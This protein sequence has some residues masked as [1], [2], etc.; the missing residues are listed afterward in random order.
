[1]LSFIMINENVKIDNTK[2]YHLY[3]VDINAIE[4]N[5]LDSLQKQITNIL[6]NKICIL[7]NKLYIKEILKY[8]DDLNDIKNAIGILCKESNVQMKEFLE[9]IF[10]NSCN[11]N[12]K[13][14]DSWK[15]KI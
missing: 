3:D 11:T 10:D 15:S 9:L 4:I 5:N 1:M 12:K 14:F 8:N 2:I 7:D 6:H 13:D